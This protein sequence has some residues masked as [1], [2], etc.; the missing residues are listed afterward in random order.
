M[1]EEFLS[2][3][4]CSG[5][6]QDTLNEIA[7]D[8]YSEDEDQYAKVKF[9]HNQTGLQLEVTVGDDETGQIHSQERYT[10]SVTPI[11]KVG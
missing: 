9:T 7:C 6:D 8:V 10:I 11:D 1:V 5:Q 4:L 2:R 3:L